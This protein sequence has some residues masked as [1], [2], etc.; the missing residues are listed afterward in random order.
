MITTCICGGIGSGKSVVSRIL[1]CMGFPVYDCD[2]RARQIIDTDPD[3]HR[4][5]CE[6]IHPEAVIDGKVNR[7]RIAAVVFSDDRLLQQLNSITHTA[8]LNDL[9]HWLATCRATQAQHAFVETAIPFS[10][11]L[12]K[13]VDTLWVVTAP[14]ELRITRVMNRNGM[15]YE[16]VMARI[17]AQD[18]EYAPLDSFASHATIVNDMCAPLLPQIH[19]LLTETPSDTPAL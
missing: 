1:L 13:L 14:Q 19:G 10:S 12:V 5:L 11:G 18:S 6:H 16:Q 15:T 8:V 3:I 7:P 17:S 2:S 9:S 4:L